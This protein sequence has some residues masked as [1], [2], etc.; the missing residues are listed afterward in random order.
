MGPP[1]APGEGWGALAAI[2]GG[3]GLSGIV[4]AVFGYLSAARGGRKG[5]PEKAAGMIGISALL[6]DA[7]SV[8]KL[9]IS[10]GQVALAAD[11]IAL[12]TA[13]DRSDAKEA[14]QRGFKCLNDFV[15]ELREL[16]RAIEDV[17]R[18][19]EDNKPNSKQP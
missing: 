10:L 2:V 14:I 18:A 5:E 7:E 15:D 12:M 17:R 19:V 11:K 13:E 6:A 8:T 16:R 4:I 9:S 3:G 1:V